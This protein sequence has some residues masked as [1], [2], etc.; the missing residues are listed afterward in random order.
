MRLEIPLSSERAADTV[1]ENHIQAKLAWYLVFMGLM[2]LPDDNVPE[3]AALLRK[4]TRQV[5]ECLEAPPQPLCS[6]TD[7]IEEQQQS[8]VLMR[9]L[10]EF[11]GLERTLEQHEFHDSYSTWD[12]FA[13]YCRFV[14]VEGNNLF[15]NFDPTEMCRALSQSRLAT[16]FD[17]Q[18][19]DFAHLVDCMRQSLPIGGGFP[20]NVEDGIWIQCR[21]RKASV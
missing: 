17:L 13:L 2:M 4:D 12:N 15:G 18:S 7:M 8:L 20:E 11:A 5:L 9:C 6:S 19:L 21:H 10:A 14:G 3:A 16:V 1:E